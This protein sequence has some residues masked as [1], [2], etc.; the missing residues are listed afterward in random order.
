M[1]IQVVPQ[2][3]TGRRPQTARSL[4]RTKGA[5]DI[6]IADAPRQS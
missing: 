2:S 5:P 6:W 4:T 1:K 3:Q